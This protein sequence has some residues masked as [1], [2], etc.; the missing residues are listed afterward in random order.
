MPVPVMLTLE[1]RLSDPSQ[2]C[3]APRW[4]A[5]FSK[6]RREMEAAEQLERQGFTTFLPKVRVRRRLRGQWREVVEPMFPRYL[7]LQ[8]T[9]GEDNLAPIR[10]TRGVVGLVRFGGEPRP[11]PDALIAELQRLCTASDGTLDLPE[12]LVPGSRVRILEGP[13]A[14]YEAELLSQDGK[15]RA[16]VLLTMLGQS[17]A[18]RMPLNILAPVR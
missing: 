4:F 7:F 15:H 18:V 6:P 9:L 11:V 14:G 8:A 17:H 5:V 16:R 1:N 2:A 13:F 12:P 10:S 3:P